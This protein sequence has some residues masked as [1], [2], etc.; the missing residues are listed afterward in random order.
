MKICD[1]WC[2]QAKKVISPNFNKRP[3]NS[4]INLLVIHNI[5][6]PPNQFDNPYIELFFQNKLPHEDHPYFEHLKG[7]E[8][9]SHFL[10]KRDGQLSQFVSCDE[11]AWHAGES[12]FCGQQNCNDFSIGIELEGTDTTAY[13]NEQYKAL[14]LLTAAVQTAYPNITKT[15]ITGHE[16]IAPNRK[17]D[18]GKSFD[19]QRYLGKLSE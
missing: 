4:K 18:P 11:R 15:R 10:I 19:W 7:V 16:H 13:T 1:G 2:D 5:S 8:V 14:D 6:L 9:S 17:T 3:V 12:D